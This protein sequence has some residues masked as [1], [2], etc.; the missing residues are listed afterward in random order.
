MPK[1]QAKLVVN[2]GSMFSGK[3]TELQRQGKRH[4]IAGHQVVY[5]KPKMDNRYSEREVVTH[6]GLSAPA[7]PI[8][9]DRMMTYGTYCKVREADVVLVD[10][11]QF[12]TM[13]MV[14]SIE[15]LL[16]EGKTV[17]VSGLDMDYQGK[18]FD[19]VSYLMGI[20]DQ[21][22]KIKAV[23]ADCGNDAYVTAKTS[24]S[25]DRLELGSAD[26]YKPVCRP[27]YHKLEGE[28]VHV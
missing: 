8:H 16:K 25:N 22:H 13:A 27:C 9:T 4:M 26:I 28:K 5:L 12:F 14:R 24:G 19:V 7:L 2:V 6:D 15:T 1:L 17:Y 11:V 3:S 21:V 10:E 20:A 18:P 23:C